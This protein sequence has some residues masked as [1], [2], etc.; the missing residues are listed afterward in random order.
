MNL[1]NDIKKD[2]SKSL[3]IFIAIVLLIVVISGGTMAYFA[4]STTSNNI[5]G[6]MGTVDLSLSVTKVLP[7]GSSDDDLLI[8]KFSD[9]ATNIN[10]E[11]KYDDDYANCQVY[12]VTLANNSSD[13]NTRVVGSIK[14]NASTT[15]NLS[16]V[17]MDSYSSSTTYT[18]DSFGSTFNTASSEFVNFKD[19]Y[20]LQTGR[21]VD[22]YIVV[23]INENNEVQTDTGSYTGTVRF[24]DT[25]GKGVTATF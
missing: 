11:C 2:E 19:N 14:F 20:L 16:W 3:K 13:V 23:W 6:N 9:L 1:G 12:K 21:S 24:M 5:T 8:A 17:F 4:F 25:N 18:S 7:V 22:F 15:P 10:N